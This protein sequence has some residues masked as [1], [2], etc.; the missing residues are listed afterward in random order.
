[1]KQVTFAGH[2]L[3]PQ[4][5]SFP[6]GLLPFSTVMD[7][8]YLATG[9]PKYA[10]AA[11]LSL[12]GGYVGG[13]AAAV[14]GVAD[15]LTISPGGPMKQAANTHALLNTAM[16]GVQT[17]NLASRRKRPSGLLPAVFSCIGCAG[18]L[19]SQWYG[20]E[21]VYKFGMRVDPATEKP[22]PQAKLPGDKALSRG[23]HR[24]QEFMPQSG[25]GHEQ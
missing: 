3:H 24:I 13:L 8:M 14:S 10:H 16:M 11:K 21:L 20:G 12:I 2:P 5:L 15:Y 4:I 19:I 6:L 17:A 25:P 18:V 7:L 23:L 1:M 22:Q 9:K